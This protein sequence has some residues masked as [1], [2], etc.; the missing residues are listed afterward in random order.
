MAYAA[1]FN[2]IEKKYLLQQ[3]QYQAVMDALQLHLQPDAFPLSVVTSLYWDTS[4]NDIISRSLEKPLYKEKLRV[5]RYNG[6]QANGALSPSGG[7]VFV[8]LKKKFKGVVYKRRLSMVED[9]ARA[10]LSG[11]DF[12]QACALFPLVGKEFADPTTHEQQVARE[13]EAFMARSPE[14]CPVM[15]TR[16]V[17]TAWKDPQSQLRITFDSPI[18]AGRPAGDPFLMQLDGGALDLL[19]P[20]QVLMEVKQVG[21]LPPWL[22]KVLSINK[23]YP[24]SFSKYGT[25]FQM[26]A[27]KEF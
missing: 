16:C 18:Q 21:G 3:Q 10:W 19:E 1:T 17:R 6:L 25:A 27:E 4:S 13:I 15:I 22:R 7:C 5:R 23:I 20:G 9:G 26:E 8:E 12:Q 11:M 14:A 24:Q 2:R